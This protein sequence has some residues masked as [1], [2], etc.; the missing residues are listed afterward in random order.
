MS[1][2]SQVSGAVSVL[3][4]AFLDYCH[5]VAGKLTYLH[6]NHHEFSSTYESTSEIITVL[7]GKY[8]GAMA[9]HKRQCAVSLRADTRED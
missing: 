6:N 2:S 3:C 5:S 8:E 1:G 4:V 7:T 9:G